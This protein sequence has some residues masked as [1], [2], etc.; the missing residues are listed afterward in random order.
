MKNVVRLAMILLIVLIVVGSNVSLFSQTMLTNESIVKMVN[1][2]LDPQV[3]IATIHSTPAKFETSF[4]ALAQMEKQG[5]PENVLKAMQD[6]MEGDATES[7]A[8]TPMSTSQTAEQPAPDHAGV[9][10]MDNHG[11]HWIRPIAAEKQGGFSP[12]KMYA[13]VYTFGKKAKQEQKQILP[14]DRANVQTADGNACLLLK[15]IPES[16]LSETKIVVLEVDKHGNRIAGGTSLDYEHVGQ[17]RD[18]PALSFKVEFLK[19]KSIKLIPST[20]LPPG[21]YALKRGDALSPFDVIDQ[22]SEDQS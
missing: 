19:D 10:L 12:W 5:V 17:Q 9:F 16:E 1:A 4:A 2:K 13:H 6:K 3:I 15:G 22:K 7:S 21:H 20:P 18:Q 14:G 11:V 8:T